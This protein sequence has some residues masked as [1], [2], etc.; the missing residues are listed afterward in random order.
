MSIVRSSSL[1]E[2]REFA[3]ERTRVAE[4]HEGVGKVGAILLRA[5]FAVFLH[6]QKWPGLAHGSRCR[7][8]RAGLVRGGINWHHDVNA[9]AA[10][11]RL[12]ISG[13]SA[14]PSSQP[15]TAPAMSFASQSV[16]Q[17]G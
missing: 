3:E 1:G 11:K 6:H 7:T 12:M 15:S 2:L 8:P 17:I 10:T 4:V 9:V 16:C 14:G 13:R 5:G